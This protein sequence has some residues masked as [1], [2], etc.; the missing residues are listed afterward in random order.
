MCSNFRASTKE[1]N[2]Q[3]GKVLLLVV[4]FGPTFHPE[5]SRARPMCSI[6]AFQDRCERMQLQIALAVT[7]N[8]NF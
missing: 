5:K 2:D 1:P 7:S 6:T 4:Q 3:F 8:N